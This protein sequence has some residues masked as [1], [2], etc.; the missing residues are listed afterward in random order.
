MGLGDC[1][2]TGAMRPACRIFLIFAGSPIISVPA[3]SPVAA[4][5]PQKCQDDIEV[6]FERGHQFDM[7]ERFGQHAVFDRL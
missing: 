1:A 3:L 5:A 2:T 6:R 7:P 4:A